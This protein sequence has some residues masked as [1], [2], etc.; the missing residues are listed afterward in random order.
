MD[1]ITEGKLLVGKRGLTCGVINDI[2]LLEWSKQ[3]I[4][5]EVKRMIEAGKPGGKFLFGTLLMPYAIPE[6]NIRTMLEAAYKY[7]RFDTL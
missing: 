7:G 3:E 1:D 4:I 5:A 2:M 6:E